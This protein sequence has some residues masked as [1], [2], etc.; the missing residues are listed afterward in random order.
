MKAL[1]TRKTDN[2]GIIVGKLKDENTLLYEDNGLKEIH[3]IGNVIETQYNDIVAIG[4]INKENNTFAVLKMESLLTPNDTENYYFL[5][6][7]EHNLYVTIIKTAVV[8]SI[9]DRYATN[10][11][12]YKSITAIVDKNTYIHFNINEYKPI[13]ELRTSC[14]IVFDVKPYEEKYTEYGTG[15]AIK[16]SMHYYGGYLIQ[17]L[18]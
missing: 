14:M 15:Y 7:N 8:K 17:L 12:Q 18:S 1:L 5:N 10:G 13:D 16:K 2:I 3:L 6:D 4:Q 11:G 9:E